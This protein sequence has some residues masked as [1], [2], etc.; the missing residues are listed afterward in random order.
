MGHEQILRGVKD[1]K[2]IRLDGADVR[3]LVDQVVDCLARSMA[4]GGI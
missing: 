1:F 4:R 2:H 3:P